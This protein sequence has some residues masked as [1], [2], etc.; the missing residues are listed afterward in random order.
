MG[1]I[2]S[3]YKVYP[4]EI[5]D[6][7]KVKESLEKGFG[8]PFKVAKIEVEPIAFGLKVIKLGVVFPDKIDGLLDKL[9]DA[10]K[11]IEGVRDIEIEVS[12]LL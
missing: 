9:E 6:I 3:V 1:D 11:A 5:E 12:T 4:E 10:I 2:L 7:D 8:D